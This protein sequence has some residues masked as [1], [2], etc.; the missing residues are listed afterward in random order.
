MVF[1]QKFNGCKLSTGSCKV[2]TTC[3]ILCVNNLVQCLL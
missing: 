1:M 3:F 2:I